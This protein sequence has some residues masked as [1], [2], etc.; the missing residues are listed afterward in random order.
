MKPQLRALVQTEVLNE[1]FTAALTA[2]TVR[3]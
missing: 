1:G 2:A 3:V